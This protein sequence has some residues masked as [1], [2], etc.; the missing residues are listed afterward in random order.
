MKILRVINTVNPEHG[1]PVEALKR[2]TEAFTEL[3]HHTEVVSM[4]AP[5]DPWVDEFPHELHALGPARTQSYRYSPKLGPWIRSN[6][7]RFDCVIIHALWQHNSYGTWRGLRGL[8]VPYFVYLHGSLD[9]WYKRTYPVKHAKKQVYWWLCEYRVLRQANGVFFTSEEE[10][11]LGRPTFRPNH[12]N[13]IVVPYG[14][15]RPIA[16]MRH[17]RARFEQEFPE[18][19]G[20]RIILYVGRLHAKKGC[21]LL[22]EA[23]AGIARDNP[24]F[25]LVLAGPDRHGTWPELQALARRCGADDRVHWI[26]MI[27]NDLKW[28]A[29]DACEVFALPSHSENFG[30]SA[31]EALAFERPVLLSDKVMIWREI[32]SDAAGLAD[33]DDLDGTARLLRKWAGLDAAARATM[34]K[35]AGRCFESRFEIKSVAQGLLETLSRNGVVCSQ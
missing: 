12:Y 21:D 30:V 19:A 25:R 1:G 34:S 24:E 11:L 20:K 15:S 35:R 5:E 27:K 33:T 3:G 31:V 26:G 18:L 13:A 7:S 22:I 9:P 6:A 23:F 29:Y 14:T 10:M 28:G 16:D 4:D 8:S 17:A 2:V 32:V